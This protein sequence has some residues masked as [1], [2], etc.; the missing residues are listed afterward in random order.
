VAD[1][2]AATPSAAAELDVPSRR[3]VIARV[4]SLSKRLAQAAKR[5][6]DRAVHALRQLQ[7]RFANAGTRLVE[8]RRARIERVAGQLHALSPLNTLARGF[9]VARTAGG[10]TLSIRS[11]FTPGAAFELW[12]QD[13]IVDAVSGASRPLPDGVRR[14]T[15]EEQA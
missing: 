11:E 1:V 6:E 3:E 13:G 7:Q 8:R 9:A 2:R 4:E 12:L 10:A 14:P 15:E 5:R